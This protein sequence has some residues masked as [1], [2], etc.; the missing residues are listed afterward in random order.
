M[1]NSVGF[2]N[3]QTQTSKMSYLQLA[4]VIAVFSIVISSSKAQESR[5]YNVVGTKLKPCSMEPLTGWFRD[6]YCT[7]DQYDAGVHVVCGTTPKAFL[8]YTKAQGNDLSTPRGSFPGLKPGDRWALC[9]ARWYEAYEAGFA[10]LIK[11]DATNEVAP[12]HMTRRN[13]E[14]VERVRNILMKFDDTKSL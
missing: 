13:P 6:G 3:S 14:E 12:Y 2:L 7:Y 4:I 5:Q 11:L 8:A 10:P 9:A 1:G